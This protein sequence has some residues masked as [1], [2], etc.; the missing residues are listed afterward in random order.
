[1]SKLYEEV[2]EGLADMAIKQS[3]ALVDVIIS[4]E[5]FEKDI[6]P[7]ILANEITCKAFIDCLQ[8]KGCTITF[9]KPLDQLKH[10]D[11]VEIALKVYS[12]LKRREK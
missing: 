10:Q 5:N 8:K 6:L 2:I 9:L 7:K 11:F 12:E 4:E 1:M 3:D